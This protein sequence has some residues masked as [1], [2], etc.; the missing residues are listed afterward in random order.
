MYTSSH[1]H[2]DLSNIRLKDSIVKVEKA[3]DRAIE[4]KLSGIAITDHA[5][6]SAHV[7]AEKHIKQ[8]IENGKLP[9]GFKVILGEEIYLTPNLENKGEYYHFVLL[10]K[11]LKGHELLRKISTTAW[12]NSYNYKNMDR[13]PIEFNEFFSIVNENKG[14]LIATTACL[15]S[16]LGKKINLWRE[17]I[18]NN[19]DELPIKLDIHNFVSECIKSFGQD[20]YFEV[21]PSDS[22]EQI[23]YNNTLKNLS[24]A[25][26]VPLTFATDVHYLKKEDKIFHKAF[27]NSQDGDREVDDFYKTTYMMS[28]EEIKSYLSVSFTDDE[29]EQMRLNSVGIADKCEMYS[30]YKPQHVPK[31]N[32]DLN[33][34]KWYFNIG[35]EHI[36]RLLNV[37]YKEDNYWIRYCLQSLEEKGLWKDE[38]LS[39]L[40]IEA[41]QLYLVSE[42][43]GQRLSS[44]FILVQRMIELAWK[45]S[46]VGVGRGSA[47][48]W[49]SNYL[50]DI[51]GVDPIKHGLD[52]WWRFLSTDRIELPDYFIGRLA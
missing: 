2:T 1:L 39:R 47:V 25:Y 3:I 23:C 26:N 10:A 32:F 17:V 27:L 41:E 9:K 38:Y 52:T 19:E 48:G 5:C 7:F 33:K 16:Y 51:T 6:L 37:K 20:F 40:N 21:Q 11:D 34:V 13:V 50:M 24:K 15:G 45:H 49:L 18:E 44:Y 28:Y 4:M 29:I 42:S 22:E 36:D 31:C 43:M 35:Y 46:L 14:H 8:I 12:K 30:L